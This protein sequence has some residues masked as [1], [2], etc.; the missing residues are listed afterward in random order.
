MS[1]NNN[2]LT[3]KEAERKIREIATYGSV[4]TTHHCFFDS[5]DSRNFS[6]QDVDF[7]LKKGTVNEPPEYDEDYDNWKYKI[8]GETI[9]GDKAVVVTVILSHRELLAIT[10]IHKEN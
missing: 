2:I 3:S 4:I 9:D 10:I 8:E 1:D 6:N 5:M 7:V